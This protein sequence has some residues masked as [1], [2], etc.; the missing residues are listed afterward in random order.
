VAALG[1]FQQRTA[2]GLL[3]VVAMGGDSEDLDGI[4]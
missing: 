1:H 4:G 2:A 3:N